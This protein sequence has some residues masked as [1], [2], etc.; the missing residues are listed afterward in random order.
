MSHVCT[1][2]HVHSRSWTKYYEV[3]CRSFYFT[4]GWWYWRESTFKRTN[5]YKIRKCSISST[6]NKDNR[7]VKFHY[8]FSLGIL[9]PINT[10]AA[11][12]SNCTLLVISYLSE[13]LHLTPWSFSVIVWPNVMHCITC[14]QKGDCIRFLKLFL[15]GFAFNF[16]S[17]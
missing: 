1:Y 14:W 11:L 5:P 8:I 6:N 7:T 4:I 12:V 2:R 3:T 16:R 13:L 15:D 9:N 10:Q 17:P